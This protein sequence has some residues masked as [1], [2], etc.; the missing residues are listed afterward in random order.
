MS[1]RVSNEIR[2]LLGAIVTCAALAAGLAACGGGGDSEGIPSASGGT[3]TGT[4]TGT[5]TDAGT[6]SPTGA[7]PSSPTGGGTGTGTASGTGGNGTGSVPTPPGGTAPGSGPM[8]LFVES[9]WRTSNSRVAVDSNG[10]K[11]VAFYYYEPNIEQRP[12]AAAY[13]YCATRCDDPA[14]WKEIQLGSHARSVQLKL[15]PAGKPR[16]L[17]GADSA[18]YVGGR[19][20]FYATCDADCTQ[21]GA[22]AMT[23]IFSGRVPASNLDNDD[24][25]PQRGFALDP[26]GRPRFV[27]FDENQLAAPEHFGLFYLSCD[28]RCDQPAAWS[29]TLITLATRYEVERV[30]Q[31]ALSFS[32]DGKPR[33]ATAQFFPVGSRP[34]VLMYLACDDACNRTASWGRAELMPRGSGSEPSVDIAVDGNGRPRI[35]FYQEALLE[36]R[37]KRLFYLACDDACLDPARWQ[38]VDVGLGVFNGQEPDLELDALGRPRIAYADW[39]KGGIGFA[40][41]NQDCVGASGNWQHRIVEDRDAL[42]QAWP[43]AYPAHCTG[44]LWNTLTPTLALPPSGPA[45][46]AIDA[47]YHARCLYD[48]NPSDNV[49]P[50]S[51]MNLITRAFRLVTVE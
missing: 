13:R 21:A 42:Y 36:G 32:Q 2:R 19:D 33:I 26:Q 45:Q 20:Y 31:P 46:I 15:T 48:H 6:G 28:V 43:V 22:W 49:P 41:C 18:V 29:E 40:W 7:D 34:A 8:K 23:R 30:A 1:T 9:T 39:E 35:A 11:H 12:T 3:P 17:I 25:L 38:G 47:T 5:P 44:G 10:G 4:G 16:L 24:E 51:E 14:S 50:S 37:G 27:V